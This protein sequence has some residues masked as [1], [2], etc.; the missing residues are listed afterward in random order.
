MS[1]SAENLVSKAIENIKQGDIFEAQKILKKAIEIDPSKGIWHLELARIL[2]LTDISESIKFYSK[3]INLGQEVARLEMDCLL[4]E[5]IEYIDPRD[6]CTANRLDIL[7]KV[8]L[9][10]DYLQG[11]ISKESST[12]QLYIEH[13]IKRTNGTE[14]YTLLKSKVSDYIDSFYQLIDSIKNKGFNRNFSIPI[15]KNGVI[16]NG[17]HRLA[18]AIALEIPLVP[19]TKFN[20]PWQALDWGMSWFLRNNFDTV[21]INLL[22]RRWIEVRNRSAQIL[23]VSYEAQSFPISLMSD[24]ASRFRITAWRDL[25]PSAEIT[26]NIPKEISDLIINYKN[27]RY[28]LLESND[29]EI[30]N[31]LKNFKSIVNCNSQNKWNLKKIKNVSE[32]IKFILNEI[33]L[34]SL[35]P[36]KISFSENKKINSIEQWTKYSTHEEKS[37]S[38]SSFFKKWRNLEQIKDVNTVIDVGVAYGTPDLYNLL[39]PKHIIF[40]E[41]APQFKENIE[42][43]QKELPSSQYF[44]IG[45][46]STNSESYINFREDAPIL[47]SLLDSSSL[48]DNG[49]EIISRTPVVLKSFDSIF[50]EL[51]HVREKITLM[52]IDTEGYELEILSGAKDNLKYIKYLMLEVSMIKRFEKS[53]EC[54]DIFKYLMDHGFILQTC[55]SAS[56]DN[57]GFCRVIDAVFVNTQYISD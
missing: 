5:K 35:H 52:K 40:I 14:P 9:A 22:L 34:E 18:A 10:K 45:L 49:N 47:T 44:P 24:L 29:E 51:N 43:L 36:E 46:S 28:I 16:L 19:I 38:S 32:F 56:V 8:E 1:S 12:A 3:A 23:A 31:F 25:S 42:L 26:E 37:N 2:R 15:D 20:D 17:A 41:P 13:I 21:Q 50:P 33:L 55:L 27:T 11:K 4:G 30:N 39:N 48:R 53:Y 6:L 57:Q 54:Q 7:I